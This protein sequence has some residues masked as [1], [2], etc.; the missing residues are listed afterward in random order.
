MFCYVACHLK[1]GTRLRGVGTLCR[2]FWSFDIVSSFGFRASNLYVLK[3]PL[4]TPRGPQACLTKPSFTLAGL[5]TNF[6]QFLFNNG[7]VAIYLFI[8]G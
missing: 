2:Q 1:L 3:R 8:K 7:D 6:R 5:P 4:R